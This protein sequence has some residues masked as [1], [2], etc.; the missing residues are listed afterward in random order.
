MRELS[1]EAALVY[2]SATLAV[3]AREVSALVGAS[4][5][6]PRVLMLAEGEVA[7][8]GLGRMLRAAQDVDVPEVAA[9]YLRKSGMVS[10]FR[11]R[12]LAQRLA[13]TVQR[14]KEEQ[15]PVMLLKGAAIGALIDPTFISRPMTDIDL[16]V[17]REDVARARAAILAAGWVA[18]T[19]QVLVELLQDHH[20]LPPF[21]DPRMPGIRLELHVSIFATD[22]PFAFEEESLWR[23]SRASA[24][25]FEGASVP[26]PEHLLLHGCLHFAWQH[27]M[28]FGAWRTFRL[29]SAL[30]DGAPPD[31]ER[32]A[33]IA[34]D[35]KGASA[36]Y[37]TLRL[38]RRMAGI[39]VPEKSLD[40]LA[41]PTPEWW[42]SALERHF[43]AGI[44]PG[45][46]PSS[47]SVRLSRVLWRSAL[48]P[49]WSGH[50]SPGRWD[51]EFRWER[52]HGLFTPETVPARLTRHLSLYRAWTAFFSRTL[53]R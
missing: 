11:M 16:L 8:A 52:A 10:D 6:W 41:P 3:G 37:W 36:C 28:R 47:P 33:A 5:D 35:A 32:F 12:F 14:L 44:V 27:T 43:I 50:R 21:V 22:H 24:A 51:P 23:D 39:A 46:S 25:P 49:K 17:R 31:W 9:E 53:L 1:A 15:V 38:A 48:R 4:Q 19:N 29:V 26:S 2:R 7:T 18:T 42:C 20:H 45:E 40:R 30:L 13:E 34:R